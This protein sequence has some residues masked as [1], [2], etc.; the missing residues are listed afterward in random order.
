MRNLSLEKKLPAI[1]SFLILLI[2]LTLSW[3]AYFGVRRA[4]QQVAQERLK[5]LVEQFRDIFHTS[6]ENL[7]ASTNEIALKKPVVN[8]LL[9]PGKVDL[10]NY[11]RNLPSLRG[12]TLTMAFQVLD[13]NQTILYSS[14]R[15]GS[16]LPKIEDTVYSTA[17][18]N[19]NFNAIGRIQVQR[20]TMIYPVVASVK[21]NNH[22][23]GY[24]VR[25]RLLMSSRKNIQNI[26]KL[27]GE[28]ASIYVG[29]ADNSFWTN[30]SELISVHVF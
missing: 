7:K 1:I 6:S 15:S 26:N 10:D 24:L 18:V 20:D 25:W 27:L 9:N 5:T 22:T 12:D 4:S 23:I 8:L 13:R 16:P 17:S 14:R 29:N 19:P 28:N 3:T 11:F 2:I 21:K 30:F